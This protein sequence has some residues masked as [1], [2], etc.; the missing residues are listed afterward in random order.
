MLN[1]SVDAIELCRRVPKTAE[2]EI[3][4]KQLIRSSSGIGANYIEANNAAS[5]L[6]FRN[7]IFVAKKE[8]AETRYWLRILSATN[9]QI[10]TRVL[11][12]ECS[13]FLFILQKIISSLK[14]SKLRA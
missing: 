4:K 6:Y 3:I 12:D 14:A 7:K 9:P 5:K 11:L 10:D 13:Q 8:A 2:N 1:F